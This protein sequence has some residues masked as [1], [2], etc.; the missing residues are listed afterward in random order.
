MPNTYFLGGTSAAGFQTKFNQIISQPGYFT[1]ILKGGPGTGKSTLMKKI[2]KQFENHDIELYYCS[3]DVKS[4][5]AVVIC[6]LKVAIVDG[7]AP[8]V[9]NA[10]FP[11]VAQCLVDL[12]GC[13]DRKKLICKEI[14]IRSCFA[15]NAKYHARA[16]KF[17]TALSHVNGSI[18]A[19]YAGGLDLESIGKAA[20]TA[21]ADLPDIEGHHGKSTYKQLA[22]ITSEGYLTQPVPSGLQVVG[23]RD[24][25]YA[26][27]FT[28]M[29]QI[30]HTLL[31]K[32]QD[33]TVSECILF[34]E[35][36][37]EHITVPP[38]KLRFSLVNNL[39]KLNF[40]H[41]LDCD[42]FYP[43]PGD[44][45]ELARSEAVAG[46]LEK[47]VAYSV[48]KALEIHDELE[49]HYIGALDFAGLDKITQK[50]IGEIE[51]L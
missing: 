37:I 24:N 11:G 18:S 36:K 2:A 46:L 13:W 3:S 45:E 29:E 51:T 49:S 30:L 5:D 48:T 16:R 25:R 44:S 20:E 15:E 23:I 27:G 10:E 32:G 43:S 39:N 50:I 42:G 14:E 4:L 8:H 34:P 28:L 12:G 6:D 22:A 26:A 1:Y 33:V 35:N 19:Q 38:Y 41:V 21:V 9:F 31:S 47:E 40:A 17:V 7:T